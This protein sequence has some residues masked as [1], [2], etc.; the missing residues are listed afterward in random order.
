MVH[1]SDVH[2]PAWFAT[3]TYADEKIPEHG[4]LCHEDM[5]LFLKR[6]RKRESGQVSYYYCGEYGE[7]TNRPHYHAVLFGPRFLDRDYH[8]SRSGAPVFLSDTLASAWSHGLCEVTG[9]TYGGALYVAGYVRKKVRVVD[10]A[11]SC[12]RVDPETGEI[13]H[14]RPEVGR[15]SRRPAIGKRWIERYWRDVYPRDFVAIDGK[16]FK[17]P[18]FYDRW[19][20]AHQPEVMMNVRRQRIE[21][22]QEIDDAALIMREKVHRA[23]VSLF[24]TRAAV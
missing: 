19:M 13:V 1:E 2:G 23:R 21:D 17:P 4:S 6:L 12:E 14:V 8:T 7:T 10:V 22:A 11:Q 3:L 15:M 20:E 24:N 16:E 5:T 18:R 9:L